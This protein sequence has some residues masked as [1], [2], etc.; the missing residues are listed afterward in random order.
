MGRARY[1]MPVA[2]WPR[3][4]QRRVTRRVPMARHY[5]Q[6]GT[7]L[8][9]FRISVASMGLLNLKEMIGYLVVF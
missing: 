8:L 9:D 4:R 6:L 2:Q 1:V 7:Q 5:L 3:C